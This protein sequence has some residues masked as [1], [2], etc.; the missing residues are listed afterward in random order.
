MSDQKQQSA[1]DD[2]NKNKVI[3]K[4]QKLLNMANGTAEGGEHERD[5]A[6]RMALALLAKHNLDM[7]DTMV[8]VDKENR[9]KITMEQ[10]TCPWRRTV[11]GAIARMFFSNYF[12]TGIRGKQKLTY[13]FVGLESNVVTTKDMVEW[14]IKSV[15]KECLKRKRELGQNA[16]WETSFFNSAAHVIANR[17]RELQAEAEFA[18]TPKAG[19]TALVLSSVYEQEERE[20]VRYIAEEMGVK[21]TTKKVSLVIKNLDGSRQGAEFGNKINLGRQIASNGAAATK[22][23]K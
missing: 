15:T 20:N 8:K 3:S 9:T 13:T 21:I 7:A 10:Y 4:V 19:G 12:Y 17:C 1:A 16:A 6:M 14:I 5:T 23:L 11:A 18:N 2:A 22:T